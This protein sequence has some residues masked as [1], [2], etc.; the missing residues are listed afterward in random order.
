M[1]VGKY[2]KIQVHFFH[3][4]CFVLKA[5]FV[6]SVPL[7][8]HN[9]WQLTTFCPDNLYIISTCSYSPL[10]LGDKPG[11]SNSF[12][13]LADSFPYKLQAWPTSIQDPVDVEMEIIGSV[14]HLEQCYVNDWGCQKGALNSWR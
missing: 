13:T 4:A 2:I 10:K 14:K 7:L 6:C 12:P 8:A 9:T 11:L 3:F 1:V 5:R